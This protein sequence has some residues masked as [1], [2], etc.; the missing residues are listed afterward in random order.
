MSIKGLSETRRMPRLGKIH[1]GI[2]AQTAEGKTY[3]KAV[4][5]FVCP[6][7]VASI[8]GEQPREL[9]IM[10]PVED[11]DK[12]ASQWYKCYS[13]YRG[14]VCKG[15][16]EK[17]L[18]LVDV[19][20]GDFAHRDTK[21]TTMRE[22]ACQG[23][24]CTQYK[25]KKC[26]AV[27]NLQ[28][29]LPDVPGLG[30]YQLDTSSANSIIAVNSA[31][32]LVRNVCGRVSMIPLKLTVEPKEVQA[33]G[34]KKTVYVL[35]VR[36]GVKLAEIQKVA[37]LPPRQVLLPPPDEDEEP[38]MLYPDKQGEPAAKPAAKEDP[39]WDAIQRHQPQ[40]AAPVAPSAAQEVKQPAQ[41]ESK[42]Q[43][44]ATATEKAAK[45]DPESVK[46]FGDL[47]TACAEDFGIKTRAG[48]WKELGVTS[49]AAIT[50]LPKDCY[51][52]IAA[53]RGK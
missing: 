53:V 26:K 5:Y 16:G 11:P 17:C 20:T 36:V 12:F 32:D 31:L 2:K 3:P 24:E 19:A 39:A 52:Q 48:V 50:D 38:E 14:L 21:E 15:D 6:P 27:M 33:D 1:L 35:N 10:F 40:P 34:R 13:S 49:Q 22:A 18:R 23:E 43:G 29:L 9:N 7:E 44:A 46:S 25:D 28:F 42:P 51:K 37:A 41:A 4:D 30:I 8:F 47:Y 45:R